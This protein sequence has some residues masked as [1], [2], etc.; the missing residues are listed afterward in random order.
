M[1]IHIHLAF[2]GN[3]EAAFRF[4]QSVLGGKLVTLLRY[5]D[6]PA[7]ATT[8]PAMQNK[9]VHASLQRDE[10]ELAGADLPPEQYGEARGYQLILQLDQIEHAEEIFSRLAEGGSVQMA[11]QE[12]FWS[13]CYG[14]L[15]DKFGIPWEI[16][17]AN[18]E[19]RS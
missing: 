10:F 11:L 1:N 12:T 8:V 17:V 3:C 4:Y 5:A 6:S 14:M 16:N 2:N 7:A 9:I 13:P 19:S 18:S 15:R